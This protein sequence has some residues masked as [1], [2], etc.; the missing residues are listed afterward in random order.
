MKMIMRKRKRSGRRRMTVIWI[1]DSLASKFQEIINVCKQSSKQQSST[2]ECLAT[3]HIRFLPFGLYSYDESL[4]FLFILKRVHFKQWS[5]D[6]SLWCF[7]LVYSQ[8]NK[9]MLTNF[10]KTLLHELFHYILITTIYV[11]LQFCFFA[12]ATQTTLKEV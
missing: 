5:T 2:F 6:L 3:H 8:R 1:N 4:R 11:S 9:W 10:S 12:Q 7:L